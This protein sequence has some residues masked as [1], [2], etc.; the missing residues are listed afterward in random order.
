MCADPRACPTHR[1]NQF[2]PTVR[3]QGPTPETMQVPAGID[4]GF[5]HN[6]GLIDPVREA[7][8]RLEEKLSAAD[9]SIAAAARAAITEGLA[10]LVRDPAIQ[11]QLDRLRG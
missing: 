5:G 9:P 11:E 3:P 1:S 2:N 4:P 7:R 8:G 10:E 6:V